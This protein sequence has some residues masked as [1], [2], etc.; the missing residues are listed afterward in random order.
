MMTDMIK[1]V[2]LGAL[3]AVFVLCGLWYGLFW[4]TETSHLKLAKQQ[5][6]QVDQQVATDQGQVISLRSQVKLATQEKPVLSKLVGLLPYGPSLDQLYATLGSACSRSGVELTSVGTPTPDGWGGVATAGGPATYSISGAQTLTVTVQV[7]G[8]ASQVLSL[9]DQLDHAARL[10]LVT[11]V[12]MAASGT[13]SLTIQ[14]FYGSS[15]GYDP[16][17]PGTKPTSAVAATG[18]PA[19][20]GTT[21]TTASS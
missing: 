3:G 14:A 13:T 2:A 20:T 18:T 19:A 9:I 11:E 21:A 6:E 4:R 1:R 5:L 15:S 17:F 10:Y 7:K 12:S 16:V 8:G